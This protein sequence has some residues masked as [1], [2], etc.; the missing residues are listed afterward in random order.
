M[1]RLLRIGF[2][3]AVFSFIPILSW[4]MLGL[5]LDKDLANVFTLTYPLQFIWL[6]LKSV[7]ATGANICKKKDKKENAVLTGMTL[8]II[9]G[10]IIFISIAINI[11]SYIEFMNMD[12]NI[13]KEFAIY[14]VMQLY[15]QLVFSSVMEK[16]YFEG[17]EKLANKYMLI[18]NVLNFGVLIGTSMFIKNKA[19]I[20]TATLFVISIYTLFITIKQYKKFKFEL[21]LLTC[22]K[23][24]SVSIANYLF[25]FLTELF[26]LSNTLQYGKEYTVALTFTTLITDT[27]WDAFKAIETV[28]KIDISKG[29][30]NYREHRRNA[31]KLLVVLLTTTFMMLIFTYKFY[32]LNLALIFIYLSIE[33]MD[34]ILCPIYNLKI[35]YLQLQDKFEAKVTSNKILASS[36]ATV[37]S[38]LKTP[39]C[40]IIGR[41]F[42]VIEQFIV[43]NIMFFNNFKIRKNGTIEK[44][45]R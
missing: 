31:Y 6:I 5:I 14:S 44:Y 8:G 24:E 23:Y 45:E 17:K 29:N 4:I 42:S 30:F 27:Q 9:V 26:G 34:F 15:I 22:I 40:T 12:Y 41:F 32:E 11:K 25:F 7:F 28:A 19:V 16:L 10:F 38:F 1:K 2:N 36:I 35:C 37:N 13:Y 21:N 3:E 33:I 20:V 18:L 43:V 39:F